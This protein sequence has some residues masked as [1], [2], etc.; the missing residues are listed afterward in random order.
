M[1]RY[2][3]GGRW[4][5]LR[6]KASVAMKTWLA[7]GLLLAAAALTGTPARANLSVPV[8]Y[9]R[10][11]VARPPVL[12]NLDPVPRDLGLAG[13]QVALA[14]NLTTGSFMG[15][16]YALTVVSVP[17]RWPKLRPRWRAP[18]R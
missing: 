18:V 8:L 14:D 2:M 16:A 17:P 15:H 6:R 3:P 12:S 11:E 4:R 1:S 10:A 13:A 9:L 7:S 5:S